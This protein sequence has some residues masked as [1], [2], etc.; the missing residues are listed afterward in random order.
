M[1]DA[2]AEK[3]RRR[4]C[5]ATRMTSWPVVARTLLKTVKSQLRN[6]PV[7]TSVHISAKDFST[8]ESTNAQSLVTH[9]K[10]VPIAVLARPML[11][12]TVLA[13]RQA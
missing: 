10:A 5:V 7:C 8:V 12:L 1:H 9:K 6:G 11:S 2:I 3:K 13:E 4:F